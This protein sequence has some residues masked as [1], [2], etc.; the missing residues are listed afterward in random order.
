MLPLFDRLFRGDRPMKVG[1]RI[2]LMGAVVE[3]T[4][5]TGDG[6]PAEAAFHFATALE[7]P[8]LRWLKWENGVYVSFVL[9]AVGEASTLPAVTV[10]LRGE[11]G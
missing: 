2:E 1:Q 8:S 9:P 11:R 6:R 4:A 10:P 7:A 3:V 5:I